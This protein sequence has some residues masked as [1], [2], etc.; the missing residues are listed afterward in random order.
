[1]EQAMT[2]M[3]ISAFIIFLFI[4]SLLLKTIN[5][6]RESTEQNMHLAT[7]ALADAVHAEDVNYK[8][9]SRGY[10]TEEESNSNISNI[11]VDEE[12]LLVEFN[13]ILFKSIM[14]EDKYN[15]LQNNLV[16]KIIIYNNYFKVQGKTYSENY[17]YRQQLRDYKEGKFKGFNPPY[18]F[19]TE[20]MGTTYYL[21]TQDL[22]L[23]DEKGNI[24]KKEDPNHPG[25]FIKM[26][27]EDINMTSE[28]KNQ[29]IISKINSVI[30]DFSDG[31]KINIKNPENYHDTFIDIRKK[32]F[33]FFEG[34]TFI[35]IYKEKKFFSS[36]TGAD[37]TD[38]RNYAIA[39]YTL[40]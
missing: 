23:Y 32:D 34:V 6:N 3:I 35:V 14:D 1:M 25:T 31:L 8:N 18:Y 24:L 33:N 12:R 27:V 15:D 28:K 19:T 21:N 37:D 16:A 30:A 38:F 17:S 4:P 36:L 7:M 5:D 13:N 20:Y 22:Y 9:M 10:V 26:T 29:V 39:G 11:G 40:K 2:G